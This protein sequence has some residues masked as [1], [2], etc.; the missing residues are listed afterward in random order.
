MLEIAELKSKKLPE[1]QEIA[2][3]LGIKGI[4][5]QKKIDLAY[6]IIDHIASQPEVKKEKQVDSE[7]KEAP[8]K[9]TPKKTQ[10]ENYPY[11]EFSSFKYEKYVFGQKSYNG[12]A[13]ISKKKLENIKNDPF[14]DKNKQSR[15]ITAD[16]KFKKKNITLINIYTPNGNPVDTEK[17]T[18]K[19]YWLESLIK[20]L[21]S[22]A[23]TNENIIIGGDFNIIPAAED[24]HNPKSYENDALF[25]LEIRKKLRELINLG[26]HDA[27]RFIHPDKEGYTFWE[28]TSGAWQKNNG[29]RI[30]HFLVSNSLI[31]LVK[32]VKINKYPRGRLKPSDHT[33]IEIELA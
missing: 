30:D 21:K 8:K 2:K 4:A 12:V 31:N 19:L 7:S 18:Y 16:I 23:K 24:V 22:M 27:Y 13:I 1:L 10:N 6:S 14:K 28:Y 25:R 11:Y 29:M 17:Y 5:G 3:N 32:D 33:P 26:F 20:I 9:E 15:I